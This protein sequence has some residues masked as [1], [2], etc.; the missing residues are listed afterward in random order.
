MEEDTLYVDLKE[1]ETLFRELLLVYLEQEAERGHMV[2]MISLIEIYQNGL[3]N[4]PID[5]D[6]SQY[7]A[8]KSCEALYK[9]E[10][11]YPSIKRT[12]MHFLKPGFQYL[13]EILNSE[14]PVTPVKERII[15]GQSIH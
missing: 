3:S 5:L 10:N 4:V 12:L 9:I 14:T 2:S 6:K 15:T 13:D 8:A 11:A 1:D 7:W